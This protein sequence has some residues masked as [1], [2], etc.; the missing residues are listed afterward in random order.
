MERNISS[1]YI[2]NGITLLGPSMVCIQQHH[3]TVT[4]SYTHK[5]PSTI[6]TEMEMCDKNS[7]KHQWYFYLHIRRFYAS[8]NLTWESLKTGFHSKKNCR[9]K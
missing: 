4:A 2:K 9:N 3:P 8:S 6:R 5:K 1:N 7:T